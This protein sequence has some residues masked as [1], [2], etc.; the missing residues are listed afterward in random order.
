M[1]KKK[2]HKQSTQQKEEKVT[3]SSMIS[4]DVF[5]QLKNKQRELVEIEQ[6]EKEAAEK[7]RIEERRRAEK[8]KSFAELLQE[9]KK[10][11]RNFK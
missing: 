11:W 2:Q 5:T 10:D 9:D 1:K 4:N 8:N 3:L 6:Q 7:K